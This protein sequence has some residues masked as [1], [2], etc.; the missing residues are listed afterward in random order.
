MACNFL[1]GSYFCY[2]N[3]GPL[4]TQ[5]EKQFHLDSTHFSLL[6]TVY[7]I[8]NMVLPILGGVFLDRIGMRQGLILFTSIL[9]VGQ[10]VFTMGG[11]QSNFDMMIAGRVIFG[12]G[13]ESMCVAQSA[14]VSSWFKGK[15]LAFAL[16]INMSVTRLGAVLNSV[17]V[18]S[19]YDSYGLG[20]ALMVGF[21]IC[22]FSLANAFGLV[23]LDKKAEDQNPES[24]QAQLSEG[25]KFNWSDLY[26]FDISFWILTGS[27]VLTY[28]SIFPFIQV[29]SDLLQVKYHFDKI[30]AGYLF[31]VPYIISAVMSPILGIA[32]DK[33]GKRALLITFSSV[34]L[35]IAFT[36]SMNMNECYQCYNEVIPLT[37]V[38][39]GYSI[40]AAAIWGSIPY[41][42]KPHTV[43]TAFGLATAIQNIG[44]VIAPTVVGY[45]KDQTKQIDHGYHFVSLFFIGINFIG[46]ILNM[47]LYTIDIYQ[48]NGVLDRVDAGAA[49]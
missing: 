41:I 29:A 45:I 31:G 39:V 23:F 14:I 47:C 48:N 26:S 40:Y 35:I 33:V 32:I 3:P 38:G 9:T 37:L 2:D 4:E 46:L 28:M 15:E 19:L 34:V 8:P 22:V 11:Y 27:C 43:G 42:V 44:L 17:V 12:I 10:L 5:L 20:P 21:F 25:D 1:L 24:E 49:K 16:G 36:A 18:P 6:Y 13:G 7:S 30:T